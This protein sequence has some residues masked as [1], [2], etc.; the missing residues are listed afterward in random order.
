[1]GPVHGFPGPAPPVGVES[2]DGD[3]ARA[4]QAGDADAFGRLV[5]RYWCEMVRLARSVAGETEAEDCVQEA[6]ISAWHSM[7]GLLDPGRFRGWLARIVFRRALHA[8]RR[9]RL[10]SLLGLVR[11]PAARREPEAEIDLMRLFERLAP[12]QRAVLHLTVVEGMSD[13]EIGE[14]LAIDAGSVRAHRQ[15]A[16]SRLAALHRKGWR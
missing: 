4:A 16:R 2:G 6:L 15:R 11:E 10:R 14:L 1:M 13:R 9:K 7:P 8:A 5:E 3:A 12:R